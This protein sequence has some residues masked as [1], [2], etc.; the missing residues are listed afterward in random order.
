MK[1]WPR[2]T[3][4]N[5]EMWERQQRRQL[6]VL[7]DWSLYCYII[8]ITGT[9]AWSIESLCT[10]CCYNLLNLGETDTNCCYE[11]L[12]KFVARFCF[13]GIFLSAIR[14][15]TSGILFW[16]FL[17]V[18]PYVGYNTYDGVKSTLSCVWQ[19]MQYI[20]GCVMDISFQI[21]LVFGT[22]CNIYSN[23][24]LLIASGTN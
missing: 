19:R 5:S 16:Y 24:G 6:R 8:L 22:E 12:L 13:V 1:G 3:T 7:G 18:L 4:T 23:L 20:Y 2:T 14:T 9:P 21:I 10:L 11:F 15:C 17:E